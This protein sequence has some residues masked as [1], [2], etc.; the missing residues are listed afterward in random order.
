MGARGLCCFGTLL[1]GFEIVSMV[2]GLEDS[3][4]WWDEVD[5]L[6]RCS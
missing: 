1:Q 3:P 4:Q 5:F 2:S 6:A